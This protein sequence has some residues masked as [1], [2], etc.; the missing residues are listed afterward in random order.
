MKT[1]AACAL[2]MAL[3][4]A[5]AVPARA[6]VSEKAAVM[7]VVQQFVDGFNTGDRERELAACAS[8]SSIIDDFPPHV[9]HGPTACADWSRDLRAASAREGITGGIVT[10]RQPWHVDVTADR[11]YVVVPATYVYEQHGKRVTESGSLFTLA[12]QKTSRGWRI[13]GWAWAQAR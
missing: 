10:L 6:A 3:L 13:T 1:S 5:A 7:A 8:Q 11:A 12:L 4:L 9:W 2:G